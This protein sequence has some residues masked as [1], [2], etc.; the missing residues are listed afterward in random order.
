MQARLDGQTKLLLLVYGL[1]A[2]ANAFSG[3]FVNVFLWKV[4]PDYALIGWFALLQQ[5]SLGA[6]FVLGGKWVKEHN[7]MNY[8]RL[9][10]ILAVAFYTL[11]LI[12]GKGA[13]DWIWLLGI[14]LGLAMGAFWLSFNVVYFEVTEANNRDIFNGW[15]GLIGSGSTMIAPWLSGLLIGR[16]A[17]QGYN[18]MF[19]ASIVI[20][21]IGVVL[22]FW[23][24]KRPPGRA[25]Q[26]NI[27]LKLWLRKASLWHPTFFALA[28]QGLR[29]G[30]FGFLIGL[31]VFVA[32]SNE[33]KLGNYTLW[34]SIVGLISF[35]IVGRFMTWRYRSVGML[36]GTIAMALS[37]IPLFVKVHYV[38]FLLFGI[39]MALTSPLFVIPMTSTTFD[40]MAENDEAVNQRVE[41]TV[42]REL[43][44]FVGRS[45]SI[46]VFIGLVSISTKA[47]VIV[48]FLAIIGCMP[49]ISA[50][51]M[52]KLVQRKA[53][54]PTTS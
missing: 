40:L 17:D 25:Y 54:T 43:G 48:I 6:A 45:L 35:Y 19:M 22:S 2:C 47:E 52:R 5:L 49:I 26:W 10:I 28:A 27:P 11:V 24:K 12:L 1:F 16:F 3:T 7:K 23:L 41:L 39:G 33:V 44:L 51:L 30:A 20:F 46:L 36:A 32:T 21:S 38:T 14:I 42:L 37:V 53:P 9:G 29:D 13:I 18:Y 8:L 34:T 31:L 15:V 50:W 4:R